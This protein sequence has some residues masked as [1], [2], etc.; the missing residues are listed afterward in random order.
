MNCTIKAISLVS[1][2]VIIENAESFGRYI[3]YKTTSFVHSKQSTML[4][5]QSVN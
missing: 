5:N 1:T 3:P 4:I 2:H